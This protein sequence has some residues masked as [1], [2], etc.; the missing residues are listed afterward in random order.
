MSNHL[1][2]NAT[3]HFAATRKR[4][5]CTF[6]VMT[7]SQVR[8]GKNQSPRWKKQ[9]LKFPHAAP[10]REVPAGVPAPGPGLSPSFLSEMRTQLW[11]RGSWPMDALPCGQHIL[12]ESLWF[13][14]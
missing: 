13:H 14:C 4:K 3:D 11:A 8:V 6:I 2:Q 5:S 12:F 10:G 7:D 1:L 9:G